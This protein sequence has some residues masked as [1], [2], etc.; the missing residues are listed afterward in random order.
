MSVAADSAPPPTLIDELIA[1]IREGRQLRGLALAPGL[2][3]AAEGWRD[4]RA[5]TTAARLVDRLGAGQLSRRWHRLNHR[6]HPDDPVCFLHRA[7]ELGRTIGLAPALRLVERRLGDTALVPNR[8]AELLALAAGMLAV[9][10]DFETGHRLMDEALT[11]RPGHPWLFSCRASLLRAEDRR[12][13]A[14]DVVRE[15]LAVQPASGAALDLTAGLLVDLGRP[16]EAAAVLEEGCARTDHAS[17]RWMRYVMHSEREEAEPALRWLADYERCQPLMGEDERQALDAGRTTLHL[18][19]GDLDE[20]LACARRR[21]G[22]YHDRLVE[23]IERA[24]GSGAQRRRLPVGFVRQHH[25]TCA[26]ATLAALAAWWG[27]PAEHTEIAEKICYDGTPSYSERCWAREQGLDG[28]EFRVTPD[29]TRE[30]L[31]RG[32]P[33]TLV[34]TWPTGA[35][36]QA[37]IGTDERAG[38]LLIRDPMSPHYTEALLEGFLADYAAHGPRGMLVVPES[39]RGRLDGLTLPEAEVYDALHEVEGALQQ[40]DRAAAAAHYEAMKRDHP[41]HRLT[42][43]ACGALAACD[44]DPVKAEDASQALLRLH[45]GDAALQW[46]AFRSAG[47]RQPRAALLQTLEERVARPECDDVFRLELARRLADDA[48]TAPRAARLLGRVLRNRPADASALVAMADVAWVQRRFDD[49][50]ALYRLAACAADKNEGI[51]RTYAGAAQRLNRASEAI[52]FLERRASALGALSGAP[53]ITLADCLADLLRVDEALEVIANARTRRPGDGSLTLHEACLLRRQGRFEDAAERLAGAEGSV[54]VNDWLREAAALAE[55]RGDGDAAD[56]FRRRILETEPLAMDVHEALVRSA[57]VRDGM[58]AAHDLLAEMVQ[59]F[60][61]HMGIARLRVDWLRRDGAPAADEIRRIL[62]HNPADDWAWR[63][64]AL[65]LSGRHDHAG[66][67]EAAAESV[68]LAPRFAWSHSIA[69]LVAQAAGDAEAAHASARRALELDVTCGAMPTLL[70]TAGSAAARRQGLDFIRGQLEA[71]T[72]GAAA[73]GQFHAAAQPILTTEELT[74]VLRAGQAARPDL[75]ETWASLAEHLVN[76]GHPEAA[77]VTRVMTERFPWAPG[78]WRL[79]AQACGAA[80][81]PGER[82]AALQRAVAINPQWSLAVRELAELHER[83]GRVPEA[84]AVMENLVRARPLDPAN[85]GVLA[86]MLLRQGRHEDGMAALER[87][88]GAEPGYDWG[89]AELCR[90]AVAAGVPERAEA[91]ARR[92]TE[93]RPHEPRSWIV[94]TEVQCRLGRWDQAMAAADEALRTWPKNVRLHE[95]RALVFSNTG[96]RD[97]AIGA[98]RPAAFLGRI[99]RELRGREAAFRMDAADYAGAERLLTE[100]IADE[101]DYAWAHSLMYDIRRMRAEHRE[102]LALARELVR[103]EPDSAVAHGMLAESLMATGSAAEAMVP[104]RRALELDPRYVYAA[105][106]L[107]E[108]LVERDDTAK[109]TEL[110]ALMERFQSRERSL[111][112]RA[113][114]AIRAGRRDEVLAC[115]EELIASATPEAEEVAAGWGRVVQAGGS[116]AADDYAAALDRA[117]AAGTLANAGTAVF[118]AHRQQAAGVGKNAGRLLAARLPDKVRVRFIAELLNHAVENGAPAQA[119]KLLE[120]QRSLMRGE[121]ML[122]GT[123]SYVLLVAGRTREAMDWLADWP[124]RKDR[125]PWMVANHALA[126]AHV[127]GPLA[128]EA[129][130]REVLAAG[131]S[132]VWAQAA[133]GLAFVEAVRGRSGSARQHLE[134]LAGLELQHQDKFTA[135][136]AQVALAAAEH[137]NRPA[138]SATDQARRLYTAA[139]EAWPGGLGTERGKRTLTELKVFV[140]RN[141]LAPAFASPPAAIVRQAKR[142]QRQPVEVPWGV[143]SAGVLIAMGML[144]NCNEEPAGYPLQPLPPRQYDPPNSRPIDSRLPTTPRRE[145]APTPQFPLFS[146]DRNTLD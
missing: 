82:L 137:G 102:C 59:R 138:S 55:A 2:K 127:S 43:V 111:A 74:A 99:P 9:L 121:T 3:D 95:L 105:N 140:T 4:A 88:V 66:A 114:L 113:R 8:R 14:L 22:H 103:I 134:N 40:H 70:A 34:T 16:D 72:G 131:A 60:P 79:H 61:W 6:R 33:F 32:V 46:R 50:L 15:A 65:E 47:T 104:V 10:R 143:V 21:G 124:Q 1:A 23:N 98:C 135:A 93:A 31:A 76:L 94:L 37:V 73:V 139:E 125:E 97:D 115:Q 54:P 62:T 92:L 19:R 13:E 36:L 20:A 85:H 24:R 7:W 41:D 146:P 126:T 78:S 51:A 130:W 38:L 12:D 63:E 100:L 75:F 17:L 106:R 68:R 77:G 141:N 123:G 71:Q 48:R 18:L 53:A 57:A 112:A 27:R 39:E 29:I 44:D 84:L 45:P 136:M 25:M 117:L 86:D 11:L 90:R 56:G 26:P 128:A 64:L 142:Q 67:A 107:F 145:P 110:A 89:W 118:W 108:D 120:E 83:E 132:N 69:A 133:A 5:L 122:W 58:G 28:R 80:G 52:A 42:W 109:A 119:V 101:P 49:A 96:R 35:H 91:A 129:S 116:R 81:R 144:R 87:A 30:L